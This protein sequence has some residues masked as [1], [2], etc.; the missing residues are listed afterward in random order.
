MWLPLPGLFE[1]CLSL[2][3]G[4]RGNEEFVGCFF[5]LVGTCFFAVNGCKGLAGRKG[6]DEEG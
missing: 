3:H 2:V 6:V 4:R 1:F 5:A